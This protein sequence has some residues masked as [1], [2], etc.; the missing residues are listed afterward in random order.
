MTKP[1]KTAGPGFVKMSMIL[2][3][4][5]C[6]LCYT[7]TVRKVDANLLCKYDENKNGMETKTYK[8]TKKNKFCFVRNFA[9][10]PNIFS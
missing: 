7:C 5:A 9:W 1:G 3:F 2:S 6:F 4:Y 10:P 8:Q